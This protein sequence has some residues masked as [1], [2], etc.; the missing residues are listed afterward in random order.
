MQ[1]FEGTDAGPMLCRSENFVPIHDDLRALLC[2]GP[3]VEVAG[4]LLGEPAVLYKEK[5]NHKL[6]GGAG[7][8]AHQDAPAYPMIATHV[9]AMVAIDDADAD[10]GGLEVVSSCFDRVLP[11]LNEHARL[12]ED[13]WTID[14][15]FWP[16]A[17][18]VT[19]RCKEAVDQLHQRYG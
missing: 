3:L 10:N 19:K 5:I 13:W 17:W 14:L 6:P 15:C 11:L 16:D 4:A 18:P 1:H 8:S 12:V 7:Y 2:R 9:S